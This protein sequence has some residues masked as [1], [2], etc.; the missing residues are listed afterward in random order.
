MEHVQRLLEG[1]SGS[2]SIPSCLPGR[3]PPFIRDVSRSDKSVDLKRM[4]SEMNMPDRELQNRMPVGED[5]EVTLSQKKFWVLRSVV[6]RLRVVCVPP[7]RAALCAL[8]KSPS[9]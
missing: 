5:I 8:E 4:M 7:T 9:R 6:G 2:A 1:T 3:S